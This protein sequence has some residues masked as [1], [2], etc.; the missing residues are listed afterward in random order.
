MTHSILRLPWA[1]MGVL[2]E[3]KSV[4]GNPGPRHAPK[5]CCKGMVCVDLLEE[6]MAVMVFEGLDGCRVHGE[7]LPVEECAGTGMDDPQ[8][9]RHDLL[10]QHRGFLEA[11][12]VTVCE[13]VVIELSLLVTYAGE[14]LAPVKGKTFTRSDIMSAVEELDVLA[15]RSG[16]S[17]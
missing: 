15:A 14:G 1:A 13:G 9:S 10:A 8:T 12:D 11:S 5:P 4:G 7:V 6:A 16:M 3:P 2:V 17:M